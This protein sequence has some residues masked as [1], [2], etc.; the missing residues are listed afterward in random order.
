MT[1]FSLDETTGELRLTGDFQ[2]ASTDTYVMRVE[3]SDMAYTTEAEVTITVEDTINSEPKL[4]VS[5]FPL[6]FRLF[7]CLW[8]CL[9]L[10]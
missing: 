3:A 6:F 2:S 10:H 1:M 7:F 9:W 8:L 5:P 4:L